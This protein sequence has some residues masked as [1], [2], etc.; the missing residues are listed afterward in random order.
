MSISK[1]PGW[2][3]VVELRR[4]LVLFLGFKVGLA[5]TATSC[6]LFQMKIRNQL[7]ASCF[8]PS[9]PMPAGVFGVTW[10]LELLAELENHQQRGR[11]SS[12]ASTQEQL[13]GDSKGEAAAGLGR[14]YAANRGRFQVCPWKPQQVLHPGDFTVCV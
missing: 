5:S 10:G 11:G 8:G 13:I 14:A 6:D 2:P 7:L 4:M 3:E 1:A 12:C 9:I